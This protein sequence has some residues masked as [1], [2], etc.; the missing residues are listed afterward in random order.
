M[1]KDSSAVSDFIACAAILA[2][3]VSGSININQWQEINRL[4]HLADQQAQRIE[5]MEKNH[6][7]C[8]INPVASIVA[9]LTLYTLKGLIS[10]FVQSAP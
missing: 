4:S 1:S 5:V 10:C 8:Q 6:P 9:P 7:A 2:A 3:I